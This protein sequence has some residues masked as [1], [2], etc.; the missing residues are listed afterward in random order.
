MKI[1]CNCEYCINN[2]YIWSVDNDVVWVEIPKNGSYN[3]KEFR[4]K[5]DSTIK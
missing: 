1:N 3:L 4:F 2:T 5:F